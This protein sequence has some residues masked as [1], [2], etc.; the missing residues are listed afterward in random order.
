MNWQHLFFLLLFF[1][2]IKAWANVIVNDTLTV[3]LEII[4]ESCEGAADGSI[5][6]LN[7]SGGSGN[8]IY[9]WSDGS[10]S[11]S[12]DNLTSG[13]YTLLV[14]E[15]GGKDT[16]YTTTFALDEPN[17]TLNIESGPNETDAHFWVQSSAEGGLLPPACADG[18][19]GNY[20]LHI[21]DPLMPD[22]GATYNAGGL[23]S[24]GIFCVATNKR[25]ES[26]NIS[27][28]NQSNL[29]LSFDFIGNGDGLNDNASLL[30]SLNA[31]TTWIELDSSLKSDLCATE[32]QWTFRSYNLPT[33]CEN[34]ENF[35]IAFNWTNNDDNIGA[36]PSFAVDNIQIVAEEI[37]CSQLVSVE[38]EVAE[39]VDCNDGD[40]SN[41]LEI[42]NEATCDCDAGIP[43]MEPNQPTVF[44]ATEVC[45]NAVYIYELTPD[46]NTLEYIWETP[47][48]EAFTDLG[49]SI[50]I[51]WT[52]STGGNLC[53]MATNGC[54]TT[55]ATCLAINVGGGLSAPIIDCE[56]TDLNSVSISWGMVAGAINYT[57]N[58]TINGGIWQTETTTNN[59]FDVD[60]LNMGDEVNF[61][62]VAQSNGACLDSPP[63]NSISCVADCPS[64]DFN[65]D[66]PPLI[67]NTDTTFYVPDL[68]RD[69]IEAIVGEEVDI[70]VVGMG[71][72]ENTLST[73]SLGMNETMDIIISNLST[74]CVYIE[75]HTFTV[76]GQPFADA[77]ADQNLQD[78]DTLELDGTLSTISGDFT[79]T[80]TTQDGNIIAGANSLNPMIDASGTYALTIESSVG[81]KAE[82]EVLVTL[83]TNEYWAIFPAAF[84]PNGDGLNEPLRAIGAGIASIEWMIF[85][86]W[87]EKVYEGNDVTLGWDGMHQGQPAPIGVYMYLAKVVF[88]DG[89]T[90]ELKGSVT[91]VR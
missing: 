28:L 72:F 3:D 77:G 6:I 80:W 55:L 10:D 60:N 39:P 51:D 87:G 13:V 49:E 42:W 76:S 5:S 61:T 27:T 41:G 25:A 62:I 19:N 78:G 48:G 89:G 24:F 56:T 63:S 30:Y 23:C 73:T 75:S 4:H 29:S 50:E 2:Q 52:G 74:N 11:T 47:N 34:T 84:S 14:S 26:P 16:L 7:V 21:Q 59:T 9:E 79:Y 90:E 64:L 38:I 88:V 67:C 54:D 81:C 1:F 45:E 46:P 68:I 37:I 65:L 12:I 44:G 8:Y 53:V 66:L 83:L 91:L 69:D 86:R 40:C 85:N 70:Q 36:D 20:T 32:G 71:L 33:E 58:Y 17:W 31:G 35:K 82:D 57:I 22:E 43:I 18:D 15:V